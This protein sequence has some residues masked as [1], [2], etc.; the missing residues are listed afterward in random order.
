MDS[1]IVY[2]IIYIFAAYVVG[3][4][5]IVIWLGLRHRGKMRVN[6]MFIPSREKLVCFIKPFYE[7]HVKKLLIQ[8]AN[9]RKNIP[10]W[11]V[12]VTQEWD[13]HKRFGRIGKE[14]YVTPKASQTMSF[15]LPSNID[16]PIYDKRTWYH[17]LNANVL[18]RR[19]EGTKPPIP[20]WILY[21]ILG[22]SAITL[23]AMIFLFLRIGGI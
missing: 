19:G 14:V 8:K 23:I 6:I 17:W 13:Y 11:E 2:M 1:S 15:Y 12:E 10:D 5:A 21:L 22:I 7:S 3:I 4:F 9:K 20:N 16:V 18:T